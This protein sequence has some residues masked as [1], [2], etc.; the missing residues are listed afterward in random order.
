M[1]ASI[2]MMVGGAILNAATFT[3]GNYLAKYLSGD[4]RERKSG[5]TKPLKIIRPL[6]PD[7][8]VSARS[9]LVGFKPTEKSNNKRSRTSRTPITHVNSITRPT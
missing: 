6:W 8:C 7:T 2:V 1:M 9:F 3:G 4:S 5:T